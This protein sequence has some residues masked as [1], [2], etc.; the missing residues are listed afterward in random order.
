LRP[1]FEK[2]TDPF[3]LYTTYGFPFDL[4]KRLAKK[5][6]RTINE[7][8]F[9]EKFKKHQELSRTSSA[10]M[11]KVVWPTRQRKRFGCI[12]RIIFCSRLCRLFWVKHVKQRGS[13]ITASG[14][15]SIFQNEGKMTD[16]QKR[17]VEKIVNE[18]I[19]EDLPVVRSEIAK[20]EAEKLGAEHEF[21][22]KYPDS[23]SVYS[24][25]PK[26]ATERIRNIKS[27]FNRILRR[28]HVKRTSD[29][30]G[31]FKI[32]KEEAVG[33]RNSQN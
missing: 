32:Q 9:E 5:A 23:V 31:I 3:I 1:G 24:I 4:T 30:K 26:S 15:V 11:F 33:S 27:V 14:Y 19:A 25:G 28:S 18:K 16:E 17:E 21:G 2:G 29:I 12:Q 6:G 10:G 20:E 8:D 22:Q 7:K 13:N